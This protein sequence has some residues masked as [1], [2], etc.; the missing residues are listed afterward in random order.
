MT[1]SQYIR[2]T[3]KDFSLTSQKINLSDANI[4][5]STRL[6]KAK[7]YSGNKFKAYEFSERIMLEVAANTSLLYAFN[8]PN[9]TFL[10]DN[11]QEPNIYVRHPDD[12][13][14]LSNVDL[15]KVEIKYINLR[16][17]EAIFVYANV[18]NLL[19]DKS[20]RLIKE[21]N[22]LQQIK[23]IIEHNFPGQTDII[24]VSKIPEDFKNLLT[25][26]K[27]WAISDDQERSDKI[28][29]TSKAK[30]QKLLDA[31]EPKLDLIDKYL[32]TFKNKPMHYEATLIGNLGE[33]AA[34][35][36][37]NEKICKNYR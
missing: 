12:K 29:R 14:V 28:K 15:I 31:I 6:F 24:D 2:T 10:A 21:I 4:D 35:L 13:D 22:S 36:N 11:L 1:T 8:L 30:L 5:I 27:E 37:L 19:L 33:L 17:N 32:D 26:I 3:L 18:I 34:E 9:H 7:D 20:R 25:F 23:L 16:Y